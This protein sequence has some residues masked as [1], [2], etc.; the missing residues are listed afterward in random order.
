MNSSSGCKPAKN[1]SHCSCSK[2]SE[3]RESG[4]LIVAA[5]KCSEFTYRLSQEHTNSFDDGECHGNAEQAVNYSNVDEW[6][7]NE[8]SGPANL[9]YHFNFFVTADY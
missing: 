3:R 6:P 9:V 8:S 5:I 4:Q 7:A 2:P 1:R